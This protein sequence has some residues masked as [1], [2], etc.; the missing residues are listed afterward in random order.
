MPYRRAHL[1]VWLLIALTAVAFW[2]GYLQRLGTSAW[3]HHVHGVTALAWML[4]L[5]AQS[6]LIDRR[7]RIRHRWLGHAM[8][9]IVPLF[10]AGGFLVVQTMQRRTDLF[11]ATMGDR[12]MW[13]D[14]L[15]TVVF[16][17][18]CYQ[19]LANRRNP[20]LHGGYLLATPLPL[21]MAVVTRL[22]LGLVT[23]GTPLPAA[24][25]PGFNLAMVITLI[26][27]AALWRWQ[28]SSPAPF[29]TIAV[30]TLLEW[31][32]YYV[33]PSVPGWAAFGVA[34]AAAP[35]WIVGGVGLVMGAAAM[36]FGWAAVP[37]RRA[38]VRAIA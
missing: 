8:L 14:G 6:L 13:A 32:G 15:S 3:Q 21:I 9:A 38:V 1:A 18:L 35:T 7:D 19:A 31:A 17:F 28:P 2:P 22:P 10:C 25:H 36:W 12:L 11:R 4:L 20:A 30:A 29:I 34:M 37:S 16:A 33:A 26:C 23:Q 27:V 24:F 5:V